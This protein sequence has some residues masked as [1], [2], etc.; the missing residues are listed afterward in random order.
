MDAAI[1]ANTYNCRKNS[2]TVIAAQQDIYLQKTLDKVWKAL[3]F[4]NDFTDGGF[5]KLSQV[6]NTQYIKKASHYKM[7]NGQKVE[8][9]WLSQIQGICA[10]KP[11]KIRGDRADLLI[12]E[13]GGC[14][15]KGTE[16]IMADGSL[17]AVEDIKV[18]DKLLGPDNTDRTVLELHSGKDMMYKII[19]QSGNIQ[20][21]NSRH[22]IYCYREDVGYVTIPAIEYYQKYSGCKLIRKNEFISFIIYPYGYDSYYGFS[23]DKDQLFMISDFTVCHNS[24]PNSTKAFLQGDALVGIQG[25]RFGIK[26]IGG[27]F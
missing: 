22:L 12:Y 10:D 27:D 4:M 7:I 20:V 19:P 13:E 15:I 2:I 18:G 24:W 17:K 8:S 6:V 3:A 26:L 25:Q 1:A 23:L 11:N 16:V 21:V 9:G 14:H 5:F